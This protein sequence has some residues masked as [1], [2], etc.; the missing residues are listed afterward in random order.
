MT[1]HAGIIIVQPPV[2]VPHSFACLRFPTI[3]RHS[4]LVGLVAGPVSAL[5]SGYNT[6]GYQLV[7]RLDNAPRLEFASLYFATHTISFYAPS[8]ACFLSPSFAQM[9][10]LGGGWWLKTTLPLLKNV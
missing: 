9:L 8:G 2:Y 5:G 6:T 4:T 1:L 3:Y 7:G 10:R